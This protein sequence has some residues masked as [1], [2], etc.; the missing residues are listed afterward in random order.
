MPDAREQN[1][2]ELLPQKNERY[3][4]AGR[5]VVGSET[6]EQ[7]CHQARRHRRQD[8]ASGESGEGQR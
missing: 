5:D 2:L 3:R 7:S 6:I 8:Q 1:T 4:R